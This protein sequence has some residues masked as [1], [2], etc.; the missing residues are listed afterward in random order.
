MS[1]VV[2]RSKPRNAV[3]KYKLRVEN[4]VAFA[5]IKDGRD[6]EVFDTELV[7]HDLLGR[8]DMKVFPSV[9]SKCR[10]LHTTNS[11]FK[12]GNLVISGAA[13]EE[14]ALVTA[15]LMVSRLSHSLN[16]PTLHL[17][18]FKI[19]NIVSVAYLGFELNLHMFVEDMGDEVA[20]EPEAFAGATWNIMEGISFVAFESGK[21]L[22]LGQSSI[23][24]VHEAE[25]YLEHFDKYRLYHEHRPVTEEQRA[26]QVRKRAP[27]QIV[28]TDVPVNIE[29]EQRDL[30]AHVNSKFRL[31][32]ERDLEPCPVRARAMRC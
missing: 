29:Q 23:D 10:E 28:E 4:Y 32:D 3:S 7:V 15:H 8:V 24:K 31:F 12:N 1:S 5:R 6:K 27:G 11:V 25:H 16:D 14:H 22:S 2:A 19:T 30:V 9:I 17:R 20:W 18:N 26:A 21:V 13:T